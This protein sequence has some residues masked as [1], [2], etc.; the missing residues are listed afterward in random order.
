MNADL[1]NA[2]A[3]GVAFTDFE[4]STAGSAATTITALNN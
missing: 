2:N 1:I 4:I 3:S